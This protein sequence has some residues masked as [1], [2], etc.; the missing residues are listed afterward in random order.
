MI[1]RIQKWGNSQGI[2]I[3]KHLLAV[4]SMREGEELEITAEYDRII[5]KRLVK[6]EPQY[7]LRELFAGYDGRHAPAAED[8]GGPAGREVW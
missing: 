7:E 2:R 5:L 3:P 1:G 8:L 6:K 4:A